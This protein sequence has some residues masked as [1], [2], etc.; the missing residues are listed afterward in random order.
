MKEK[1]IISDQN[2]LNDEKIKLEKL[3]KETIQKSQFAESMYNEIQ[4]KLAAFA[5][6][7]KE[8]FEKYGKQFLQLKKGKEKN[9][10]KKEFID[11]QKKDK[12][13]DIR[14]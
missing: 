4:K 2:K 6:E 3:T 8:F 10:D 14:R 9:Q 13:E 7:K 12:V 11:N 5:Q 1:K